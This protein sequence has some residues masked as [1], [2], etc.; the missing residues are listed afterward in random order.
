MY[1]ASLSVLGVGVPTPPWHCVGTCPVAQEY[2]GEGLK[3]KT[4]RCHQYVF[5]SHLRKLR[6]LQ[7]DLG[8]CLFGFLFYFVSMNF[9]LFVYTPYVC[10][11][12]RAQKRTVVSSNIGAEN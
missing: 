3:V 7:R 10:S 1:L 8:V 12:H 6:I 2:S 9:C 5:I 11:T 4:N